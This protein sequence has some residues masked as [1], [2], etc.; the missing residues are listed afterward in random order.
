[1][2]VKELMEMLK[3]GI[4]P[5]IQFTT[6]AASIPQDVSPDPNM[7]GIL[8]DAHVD[9]EEFGIWLFVVDLSLWEDHNRKEA[10]R[11]W[12]NPATG[13]FDLNIFESGR[14]PS[15]GMM[16]F[17]SAVDLERD[18]EI[19]IFELLPDKSLELYK[20]YRESRASVG[21]IQWLES[22]VFTMQRQL[23]VGAKVGISL[24]ALW[25][26]FAAAFEGS[27]EPL[28]F[29]TKYGHSLKKIENYV[30]LYG[31]NSGYTLCCDGEECDVIEVCD[32]KIMLMGADH[33]T[34]ALSKEEAGHAIFK[35]TKDNF[36]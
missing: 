13:S 11:N 19:E 8:L 1:M 12:H 14:Y 10:A 22:Q 24:T 25:D 29:Y 33:Y 17:T 20:R 32:D 3:D 21:Y 35:E 30:D 27:G 16:S 18:G 6:A 26:H 9:N 34:F 4:H 2:K 15:S 31:G 36:N 7:R 28:C 5:N 23:S